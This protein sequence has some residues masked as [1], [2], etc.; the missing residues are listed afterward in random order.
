MTDNEKA[1][2]GVIRDI[3]LK[4]GRHDFSLVFTDDQKN[5]IKTGFLAGRESLKP[6]LTEAEEILRFYKTAHNVHDYK[7]DML[8]KLHENGWD[9]FGE[10]ARAY[11]AR[12]EGK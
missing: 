6:R 1:F 4:I 5:L 10:K 12:W 11:L 8:E 3:G 7:G 9:K 2:E